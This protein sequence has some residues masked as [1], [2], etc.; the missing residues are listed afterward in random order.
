MQGNAVAETPLFTGTPRERATKSN[1]L[2][3]QL[4]TRSELHGN[5]E[6]RPEMVGRPD[7][8]GQ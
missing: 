7:Y 3:G 8:P 5:V 1:W 2:N 4:K 6:N